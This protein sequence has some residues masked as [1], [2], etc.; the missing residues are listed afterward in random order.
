MSALSPPVEL[1][2]V[3]AAVQRVLAGLAEEEV[4]AA[5][6]VE[7]VR[8]AGAVDRVATRAA[9][10][11]L[12][13]GVA[14]DRVAGCAAEDE[15]EVRR[16]VLDGAGVD[17]HGPT[18]GRVVQGVRGAIR[19]AV[20][21]VARG[22]VV[23]DLVR[24]VVAVDG[25]GV[26][27]TRQLVVA[28]ATVERVDAGVAEDEVAVVAAVEGVLPVAAVD[29]VDAR[30]AV[31][32]LVAG[33]TGERVA[34]VTAD[35]MLEQARDVRRGAA[36]E[37]DD[38]RAADGRVAQRVMGVLSVRLRCRPMRQTTPSPVAS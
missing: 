2:A 26:G 18:D 20:E 8:A 22:R 5:L 35:D 37:I 11:L 7:R 27:A 25:V 6:A 17:D 9:V 38:D 31:D 3:V 24:P 32:R 12:V 28:F 15:L 4:A 16:G 21:G 19:A 1:I 23:D 29:R 33:A 30:P 14:G 34:L 10:D 36:G 13:D